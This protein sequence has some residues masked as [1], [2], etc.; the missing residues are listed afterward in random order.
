MGEDPVS[1]VVVTPNFINVFSNP[2]L[3][4][5]PCKIP[6]TRLS[7]NHQ[8]RER[9]LPLDGGGWVGVKKEQ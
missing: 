8:D 9:L 5:P 2:D 1:P 7:D 6:L 3:E 4:T